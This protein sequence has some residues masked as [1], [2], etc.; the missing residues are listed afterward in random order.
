MAVEFIELSV[1]DLIQATEF[2]HHIRP[3][4]SDK[5]VSNIEKAK[6]NDQNVVFH[7]ASL[8]KDEN[9]K[10][11][12]LLMLLSTEYMLEHEFWKKTDNG[13]QSENGNSGK[14]EEKSS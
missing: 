4:F 6:P 10:R 11:E 5:F 14:T 13:D 8:K 7:L 9:N 1:L 2:I 3:A 12:T